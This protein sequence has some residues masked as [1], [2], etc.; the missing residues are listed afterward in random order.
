[1]RKSHESL[2]KNH[3]CVVRS[4]KRTIRGSGF[5]TGPMFTVIVNESLNRSGSL[6]VDRIK[7][8]FKGER[9]HESTQSYTSLK[10]T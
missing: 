4:Q 8:V 7:A 9:V 1:M 5:T 3:S 2:K 6:E 10:Q